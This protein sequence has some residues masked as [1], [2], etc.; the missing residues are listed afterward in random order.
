M[1]TRPAVEPPG[2]V[3]G[4]ADDFAGVDGGV[5]DGAAVHVLLQRAANQRAPN[6]TDQSTRYALRNML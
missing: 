5:V 3:D 1:S 2:E 4:A 6:H